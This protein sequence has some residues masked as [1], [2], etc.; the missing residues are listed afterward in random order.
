MTHRGSILIFVDHYLPGYRAGGPVQTLSALV[1]S[2]GSKFSLFIVT[3]DRD[4]GDEQPYQDIPTSRWVRV[5]AARCI[6]L[7]RRQRSWARLRRIMSTTP[8]DLIYLNSL[9]SWALG[10][11][12]LLL[13]RLRAVPHAPLVLAPRGQ[14]DPGALKFKRDK[15]A[16]FLLAARVFRLYDGVTW[17]ATSETEAAHIRA[18]A[19]VEVVPNLMRPVAA[20]PRSITRKS[21]P[22]RIV[23][24][25]R[26]SPK[27]NLIFALEVLSLVRTDVE[28]AI[29]GPIEDQRYW[30][31]CVRLMHK[32]PSSVR[33][34][35]EGP[36]E[37]TSVEAI[38]RG[39]DLFFLPTKAENFGHVIA[40]ALSAGCPVL[41]SDQTPWRNLE[42]LG[43][44]WD[45]PLE[46]PERFQQVI[47]R[48]AQASD[49]ERTRLSRAATVL[50][51]RM[52]SDSDTI[53]RTV[54]LLG[55]GQ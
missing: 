16:I 33:A 53:V 7:S 27:K 48:W 37:H 26:I 42:T 11:K 14:L 18:S 4:L 45:L 54:R 35:Y 9:F 47:E 52:I 19:R 10:I 40:E 38:F 13:W 46:R 3:S 30:S 31:R 1:E 8:H 25:S 24:L 29:Y 44:G 12:P 20:H 28:F 43:V 51:S 22:L 50:A 32:L 39:A 17:Q 5:G 6:Y 21:G 41:I 55:R 49:E 34:T 2:L 36:A 23:F 15:K